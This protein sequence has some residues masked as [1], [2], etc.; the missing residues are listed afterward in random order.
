M[1]DRLG[2]FLPIIPQHKLDQAR[3]HV[4]WQYITTS[5]KQQKSK[6]KIKNTHTSILN[7]GGAVIW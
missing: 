5:Q 3:E 1:L 7:S 4:L 6:Q 2:N